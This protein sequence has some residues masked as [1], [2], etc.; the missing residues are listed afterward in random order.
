MECCFSFVPASLKYFSNIFNKVYIRELEILTLAI[1]CDRQKSDRTIGVEKIGGLKI[2]IRDLTFVES[3]TL[4]SKLA[5][6]HS[7][8]FYWNKEKHDTLQ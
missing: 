5:D 2:S 1:E 8:G 4:L 7:G 3:A 6:F